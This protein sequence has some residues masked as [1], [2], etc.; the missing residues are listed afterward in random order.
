[1]AELRL[2]SDADPDFTDHADLSAGRGMGRRPKGSLDALGSAALPRPALA[3][4]AVV[5]DLVKQAASEIAG[6]FC[7]P[8]GIVIN[9]QGV[10]RVFSTKCPHGFRAAVPCLAVG[11]G[12][13]PLRDGIQR[14]VATGIVPLC[15]GHQFSRS[16]LR[17]LW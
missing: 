9:L 13:F 10:I 8:L 15:H 3:Q 4:L 7:D 14:W 11:A 16:L 6:R 2:V 5:E 1:M 17:Y 12:R